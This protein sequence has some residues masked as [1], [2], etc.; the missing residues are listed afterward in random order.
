MENQLNMQYVFD[1]A[2]RAT[3]AD[4]WYIFKQIFIMYWPYIVGFVVIVISYYVEE[5]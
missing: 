4:L 1:Q 5:R 3:I 2:I